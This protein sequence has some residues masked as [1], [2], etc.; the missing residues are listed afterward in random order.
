VNLLTPTYI[1]PIRLIGTFDHT[2]L[3]LDLYG[4]I[5]EGGYVVTM[6]AIPDTT[7]SVEADDDLLAYFG[8]Q[9]NLTLPSAEEL[10]RQSRAEMR[11]EHVVVDKYW[12]T[13]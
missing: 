13:H 7:I 6:A 5:E 10:R 8:I 1:Q 11:V 3:A 4:Y 2:G 12:L 9:L